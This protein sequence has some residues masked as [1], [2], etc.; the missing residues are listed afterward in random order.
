MIK[1]EKNKEKQ[2]QF[3]LRTNSGSVLLNSVPYRDKETILRTVEMLPSLI[4]DHMVFERKTNHN[5]KFI[6]YLKDV[7]GKLIGTSQEYLS[8]SGLE[9]GIKNIRKTLDGMTDHSQL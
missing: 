9:N 7:N 5:G 4:D 1:I 8:E 3:T 6:F 2:Y